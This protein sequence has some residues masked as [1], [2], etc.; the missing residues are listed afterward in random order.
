MTEN[1][2]ECLRRNVP[3]GRERYLTAWGPNEFTASGTLRDYDYTGRLGEIDVPAL[4]LRG[5]KDLCTETLASTLC[6]GIPGAEMHVFEG[7]RHS[8]CV[9]AREEYMQT[10]LDW[11][12]RHP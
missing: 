11:M 1:S 9:D 8:C 3:R 10:V 6:R 7:A 2:P 5:T 12:E 4:V